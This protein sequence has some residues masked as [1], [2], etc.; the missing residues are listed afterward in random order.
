[1]HR[2]LV[3]TTGKWL[4]VCFAEPIYREKRNQFDENMKKYNEDNVNYANSN[5][6]SIV[7]EGTGALFNIIAMLAL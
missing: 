6:S 1:M 4:V 7:L 2:G 3:F 5:P